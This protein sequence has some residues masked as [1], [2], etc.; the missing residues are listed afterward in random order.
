M[1]ITILGSGASVGVPLIEPILGNCDP[2][3]WK[4][5]RRRLSI[6]I[7]DGVTRVL[8][9]ASPDS[10]NQLLDSNI[11]HLDGVIFTHAHAD[12]CHGIDDL[13]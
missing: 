4:N 5:R 8:V 13:R 3:N 1:K 12:H 9:D 7:E 2:E 11:S 10:R 6:L